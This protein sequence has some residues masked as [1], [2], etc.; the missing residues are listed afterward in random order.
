MSRIGKQ[1]IKIPEKVE[2][3]IEGRFIIV[4]GPKG[5]LQQEI[6]AQIKTKIQDNE[7]VFFPV[8]LKKISGLEGKKILAN[9]GTIRMLVFNMIE[10]VVE[11]FEKRLELR[12]V[13]YRAALEEKKLVLSLG[14]SHP[15]EIPLPE[16]IEFK[17]EKNIIIVSGIDKQ[18]VGQVAAQIRAKRKP[19]PYK[20]K[21]IRYV[22]EIVRRK[23]GKKAVTTTK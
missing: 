5:E 8:S 22:G 3:K 6:P 13:G 21:G 2:V 16:G 20:G 18:S 15:V 1:P 12:G 17:V 23:A 11:G 19:E 9:W 7:I 10:G 4:K 14:F